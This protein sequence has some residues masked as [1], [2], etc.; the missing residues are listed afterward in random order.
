M[1]NTYHDFAFPVKLSEYLSH[2]LP[3]VSTDCFETEKFIEA[4][5]I[6]ITAKDTATEFAEALLKMTEDNQLRDRCYKN[7]IVAR[8]QNLWTRRAETVINDLVNED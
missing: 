5:K 8:E 7:S 4:A 3:V 2:L 6:G 1:K